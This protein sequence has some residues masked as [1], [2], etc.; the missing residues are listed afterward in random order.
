MSKLYYCIYDL[1]DKV[2]WY[3]CAHVRNVS[4]FGCGPEVSVS[5][6]TIPTP[7]SIFLKD[8]SWTV[9]SADVCFKVIIV[10]F[11]CVHGGLTFGPLSY[12]IGLV[13]NTNI[14]NIIWIFRY[15]GLSI[16]IYSRRFWRWIY[17]NRILNESEVH[18][19]NRYN[20]NVENTK[21]TLMLNHPAFSR[22]SVN[23]DC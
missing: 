15:S 4:T 22:L 7:D 13:W 2:M 9:L 16:G 23:L 20:I 6:Q 18:I 10:S 19:L 21:V 3:V 8:R 5:R 1:S 17:C 14:F 11:F 12:V